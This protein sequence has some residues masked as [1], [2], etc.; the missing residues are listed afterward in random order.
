MF[1]SFYPI[2]DDALRSAAIDRK[3]PV[4]LLVSS[5]MY[6]RSAID[7]FLNSLKS[8]SDTYPGVNIQVVSYK[9][10]KYPIWRLIEDILFCFVLQRR[11]VMPTTEDQAKI[12]LARVNHNKIMVTEKAVWMSNSNWSADYFTDTSGIS[13]VM[14][15]VSTNN[16]VDTVRKQCEDIFE[17]DWNSDYVVDVESP[18]LPEEADTDAKQ[19][20][21]ACE[22]SKHSIGIVLL[23]LAVRFL[24]R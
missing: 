7:F 17:R 5:W 20:S 10:S 12:P 15:D 19:S 23:S 11:F 2:F 6:S 16:T 1:F 21:S 8:V 13:L 9:R 24:R 4:K 18:I 22:I 14:E 3:I